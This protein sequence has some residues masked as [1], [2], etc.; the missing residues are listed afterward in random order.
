MS[1]HHDEILS[2]LRPRV[3]AGLLKGYYEGR[4]SPEKDKLVAL[5]YV[6]M[7][8]I[9][10]NE[11]YGCHS[12]L[13]GVGGGYGLDPEKIKKYLPDGCYQIK[14]RD[15]CLEEGLYQAFS[16]YFF[17]VLYE[18][19]WYVL[20]H[21]CYIG[22]LTT[23]AQVKEH[24]ESLFMQEA[25]WNSSTFQPI[26][27]RPEADVSSMPFRDIELEEFSP[28]PWLAGYILQ[29]RKREVNRAFVRY[30]NEAVFL[31]AIQR[32][33]LLFPDEFYEF[34]P[35][36]GDGPTLIFPASRDRMLMPVLVAN[37]RGESRLYYFYYA[38]STATLYR[39][40]YFKPAVVYRGPHHYSPD[41]IEDLRQ[42]SEWDNYHYLNT[43]RTLDE[44][45]FWN[46]YVLKEENGTYCYLEKIELA[47]PGH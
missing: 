23:E 28:M 45:A 7:S 41:I 15:E 11:F 30:M 40:V 24:L 47:A 25:F 31:P 4:L 32:L 21:L 14:G 42:I 2:I 16:V 36:F 35:L 6:P 46:N 17:G 10:Y 1:D 9:E 20:P 26:P 27:P 44:P 19:E 5:T 39:W 18:R 12:K 34:H 3:D 8:S 29:D 37:A 22:Q 43:S 33:K 38:L 13:G